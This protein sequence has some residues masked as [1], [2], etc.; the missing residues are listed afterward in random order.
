MELRARAEVQEQSYFERSG[1]KIVEELPLIIGIQRFGGLHLHHHAVIN[2]QIHPVPR[3]NDAVVED[4][5]KNLPSHRMASAAQFQ[6]QRATI[7]VLEKS[8]AEF[9][10]HREESVDDR[11]RDLRMKKFLPRFF[12]ALSGSFAVESS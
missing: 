1:A 8:I 5:H 2:D 6:D 11:L 9:V 4:R 3:D 7:H 12:L 10:V